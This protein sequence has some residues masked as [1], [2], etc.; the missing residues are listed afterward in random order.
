MSIQYAWADL[1]Q[2]VNEENAE[3]PYAVRPYELADGPA[4]RPGATEE[5]IAQHEERL[6]VTFPQSYRQFLLVSH[7]LFV[8]DD[9]LVPLER[10]GWVRDLEPDLAALGTPPDYEVSDEDYFV[11]GDG[12]DTVHMRAEYLPE[13]LLVGGHDEG[14][15]L[16]N[17]CIETPDGE[18]EAWHAAAWMPGAERYRSFWEMANAK[19]MT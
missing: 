4:T 10:V 11:Y 5:E 6:G 17:P 2:K 7:G 18:W 13:M 12:Q 1:L 14:F 8:E 15:F 9:Y 3:R 16:L 19:L